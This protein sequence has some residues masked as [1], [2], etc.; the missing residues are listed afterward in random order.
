MIIK[1]VFGDDVVLTEERVAHI[2]K[3]HS[4]MIYRIDDLSDVLSSPDVI[5]ESRYNPKVTLYHKFYKAKHN[6]Y[7][8][9]A[10]LKEKDRRFVTTAYESQL[11]KKGK[12]LWTKN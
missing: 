6:S 9:V 1:D 7:I 8:V 2:I 12:I 3:E 4:G 5:I 11:T 10:V